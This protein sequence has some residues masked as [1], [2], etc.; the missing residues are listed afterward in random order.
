MTPRT[1]FP[2]PSIA[3]IV[4]V[5]SAHTGISK[6]DLLSSRRFADLCEAREI[7]YFLARRLTTKSTPQIGR[8]IGGRDHTTVLNGYARADEKFSSDPEYREVVLGL[9]LTAQAAA[10]SRLAALFDP[11]DV[12]ALLDQIRAAPKEAA[13]RITATEL[14]TVAVRAHVLTRVCQQIAD[15]LRRLHTVE[16]ITDARRAISYRQMIEQLEDLGF[17]EN[18]HDEAKDQDAG[19]ECARAAD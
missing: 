8:S 14:S 16:H 15:E 1:S 12:G 11:P 9:E 18:D 10:A 7:V 6:V 3:M 2:A 13:L 4:E 5:V 19:R 17:T